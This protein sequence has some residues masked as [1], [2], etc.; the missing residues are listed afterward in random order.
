MCLSWFLW[1]NVLHDWTY[2]GL[3]KHYFL[4]QFFTWLCLL[5]I[6][7]ALIFIVHLIIFLLH[8]ILGFCFTQASIFFMINGYVELSFCSIFICCF[9]LFSVLV[10]LCI[11]IYIPFLWTVCDFA[12][13]GWSSTN[14]TIMQKIAWQF[15][16]SSLSYQ[17]C[18]GAFNMPS[19]FQ[20]CCTWELI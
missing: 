3:L 16:Q 17:G 5:W 9:I 8:D 20:S 18:N 6:M 7:Q 14:P 12:G 10:V 11:Q 15:P 19:M 4:I 13:N 1:F 2:C